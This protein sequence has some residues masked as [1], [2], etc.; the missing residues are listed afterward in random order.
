MGIPFYFSHILNNHK[1]ILINKEYIKNI[2]YLD[3]NSIIY[4]N[5]SNNIDKMYEDIYNNILN[6]IRE[7]K[8]TKV[9]VAFDG[10][11]PLAKMKQQK[12]RRYKSYYL[13]KIVKN[14]IEF[15]TNQITPGTNFMNNLN[16]YLYSRLNGDI[17]VSGSDIPGE[18]EFKIFKYMRSQDKNMNHIIYGLD[19]DLIML[20]LLN[21]PYKIYLYRETKYFS[22]INNIDIDSKYLLKISNLARQIS[23][24]LFDNT[25]NIKYSVFQYCFLCFLCGN[26]FVP[27]SPMINI[28]DGGIQL[29]IRC[30]KLLNKNIVYKDNI[31]YSNLKE[32][33]IILSSQENDLL[34]RHVQWKASRKVRMNNIEEKINSIPIIDMDSEYILLN[35]FDK[36]NEILLDNNNIRDVTYNYIEILSWT[37]KYYNGELV[38]NLIY[39]RYHYTPKFSSIVEHFP[40]NMEINNNNI[41]INPIVQLLI[42]LPYIDYKYIPYDIENIINNMPILKNDNYNI[43]YTFCRYFWES[44]IECVIPEI[45]TINDLLNNK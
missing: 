17:V 24:L 25:Y 12:E 41:E 20:S 38:N 23:I 8:S 13:K 2:L 11:A 30:F 19:A 34:K 42:V 45:N 1:G 3:A 29:L 27:H 22:Y 10:V 26:D 15:N 21:Y 9:F 16:K 35:N 37:W 31:I 7:F 43:I 28:R 32:L 6:I 33:F 4:D 40:K 5:I 14:N 36:Y 39:Y 44:H 18:G